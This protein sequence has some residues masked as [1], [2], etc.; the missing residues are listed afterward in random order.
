[1]T[2]LRHSLL[3]EHLGTTPERVAAAEKV[4]GSMIGAIEKLRGRGKTL[5]RLP[6]EDFNDAQKFVADNQLMDPEHPDGFLD[7]ISGGTLSRNWRRGRNW[8]RGWRRR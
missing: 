2:T 1:M 5:A 4:E 8:A 7:P 3:A 6:L